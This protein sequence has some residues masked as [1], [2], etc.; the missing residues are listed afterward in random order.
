MREHLELRNGTAQEAREHPAQ[1]IRHQEHRRQT[2]ILLALRG[3]GGIAQQRIRESGLEPAGVR[4]PG[5][6]RLREQALELRLSWR[7]QLKEGGWLFGLAAPGLE[8]PS[9]R[10]YETRACTGDRHRV[11]CKRRRRRSDR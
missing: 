5:L 1:R 10:Y 6:C 4:P 11:R 7:R 9:S 3:G 8:A 2:E